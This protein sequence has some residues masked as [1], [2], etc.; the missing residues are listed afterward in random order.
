MNTQELLEICQTSLAEL[1][2]LRMNS[3]KKEQI[4]DS[5][6]F[7]MGGLWERVIRRHGFLFRTIQLYGLRQDT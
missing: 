4:L 2:F 5:L 1:L 6:F 3:K 7:S